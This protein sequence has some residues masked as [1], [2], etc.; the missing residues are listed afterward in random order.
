MT[1]DEKITKQ[2]KSGKLWGVPVEMWHAGVDF[3]A[4]SGHYFDFILQYI[5]GYRYLFRHTAAY[6]YARGYQDATEK[7]KQEG[8]TNV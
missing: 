1:K 4:R 2:L 7:L 8:N 3:S 5:P 6:G